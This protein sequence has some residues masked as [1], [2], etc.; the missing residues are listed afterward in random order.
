MQRTY[1]VIVVGSGVSGLT[2][3]IELVEAGRKVAL[4]SQAS[5]ISHSNSNWAQR[6]IIYPPRNRKERESLIE[7]IQNASGHTSNIRALRD[8]AENCHQSFEE[9]LI[10]KANVNFETNSEGQFLFTQEAAH[11]EPRIVYR[12]DYTGEAIESSLVS[13][14]SRAKERQHLEIL[15]NHTA[16]DLIANDHHGIHVSQRYEEQKIVGVYAFD[17]KKEIVKKL[18]SKYVVLATGGI[19]S[20]YLHHSNTQS[21]RGDGHAMARRAGA[22]L[23]NMEFIQFHPTTLYTGSSQRRFLI[24]E[25]IRGEGGILCSV[26]MSAKSWP[27]AMWFL[28]PF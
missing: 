12:G 18:M 24:S 11:Q 22:K 25:A 7:D 20:L 2:T 14:L 5:D 13:Y 6:G 16:V 15:T 17:Q 19:G 8:L 3:A 4:L 28:A 26:L 1:D 23:I 10:K 9:M 21:A 27:P